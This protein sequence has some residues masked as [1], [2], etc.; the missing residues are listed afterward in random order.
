MG[1]LLKIYYIAGSFWN[2]FM[3]LIKKIVVAELSAQRESESV[4]SS[5]MVPFG[6]GKRQ[7]RSQT[8]ILKAGNTALQVVIF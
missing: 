2:I 1:I 8:P 6:T 5:G 3:K 4:C 7:S